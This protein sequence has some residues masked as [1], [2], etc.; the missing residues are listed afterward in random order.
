MTQ[1]EDSASR[2]RDGLFTTGDMAR[3]SGST[4]RTV[5][6]Y[7]EAGILRPTQRTEGGHR[8]FEATELDKLRLVSDLRAASF[9]LDEIRGVLETKRAAPNGKA[10][11]SE[12]LAK[13]DDQIGRMQERVALLQRL[14][15]QLTEA[16]DI[17]E[18]CR[19]CS[20][21]VNFPNDCGECATL[22][23]VD[24]VPAAVSVL[25]DVNR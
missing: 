22:E 10:A 9:S 6:F 21:T 20:N 8:L 1:A 12:V 5:R 16:R 11:S 19:K 24:P 23:D 18:R 3:M 25:W 7:E 14:I 15:G 2:R 17:L 13:L 4:L